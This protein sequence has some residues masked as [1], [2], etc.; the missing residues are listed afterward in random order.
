MLKAIPAEKRLRKKTPKTVTVI[1]F[2]ITG[3]YFLN[4]VQ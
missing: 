3:T 4:N 1:P 2:Y